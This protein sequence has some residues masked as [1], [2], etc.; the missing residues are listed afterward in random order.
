M[1]IKELRQVAV[2]GLGLLGSSI[3]LALCH[4]NLG[5]RA[6]AFSH[7]ESTRKRARKLDVADIVYDNI[8]ESVSNADLV[9]LA[10]PICTFEEIFKT[11]APALKKGCIVT[12][13][14][15][16]KVLPHK[17]AKKTL[18]SYVYYVGSHPIAGSEQRGVEFGRDDLFD[19]AVCIITKDASTNQSAAGVVKKFWTMLGCRIYSMTA[20]RHDK[21]LGNVSHL[22][23]AAAAA[24]LNA[25]DLQQL[26]YC[27]K[28]FIDT[29]RI[30]SGPAN[31]WSDIFFTNSE[32][33]SKG[34]EKLIKE[35]VKLQK[36]IKGK[37]KKAVEKLLEI[38]REKRAKLIAYK[39]SK[40]EIQ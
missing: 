35:L 11:I 22:P 14:G 31:I 21:I 5:I 17:W 23:H 3:T 29:S 13:V 2:L 32:N 15:S 6:V 30:A 1:N 28:G 19:G 12:D 34:I 39:V 40:R 16:T 27:G 25:S 20:S 7:R 33:I 26:K 36:A 9:I 10:T 18:P 37:D 8:L 24:L 4:K 38:A